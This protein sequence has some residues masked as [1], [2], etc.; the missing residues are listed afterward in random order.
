MD[1]KL[2]YLDEIAPGKIDWK[3]QARIIHLWNVPNMKNREEVQSIE[4]LLLDEKVGISSLHGDHSFSLVCFFL[5]CFVSLKSG[6]IQASVRKY[7]FPKF[8]ADLQEGST[9]LIHKVIVAKNDLQFPKTNHN[10]R[11]VFMSLT[12][13]TGIRNDAISLNHF[14]FVDFPTLHDESTSHP[15]VGR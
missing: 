15:I 6:K 9:Y 3:F 14:N 8:R 1:T 12:R 5:V 4:M 10:Y 7:L 11:L 2:S 13:V